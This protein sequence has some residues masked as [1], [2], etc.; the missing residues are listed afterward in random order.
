MSAELPPPGAAQPS[1]PAP[2]ATAVRL[3]IAPV[4]PVMPPTAT[5]AAALTPATANWRPIQSSRG[6]KVVNGIIGLV[7]LGALTVGVWLAYQ[8]TQPTTDAT[9]PT[10]L[11]RDNPDT[12]FGRAGEAVRKTNDQMQE[13]EL[14]DLLGVEDP[15]VVVPPTT[16]P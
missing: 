2:T 15:E 9:T 16:V 13:D 6:R 8:S 14:L 7:V 3:A 4:T 5:G 11:L 1:L 10:T 12:V